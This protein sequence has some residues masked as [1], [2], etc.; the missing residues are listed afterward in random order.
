MQNI[1][2]LLIHYL[3]CTDY[4]PSMVLHN[5]A[6]STHYVLQRSLITGWGVHATMPSWTSRPGWRPRPAPPTTHRQPSRRKNRS[7]PC[8]FQLFWVRSTVDELRGRRPGSFS[9]TDYTPSMVFHN[10]MEPGAHRLGQQCSIHQIS[11]FRFLWNLHR[12]RTFRG[13]KPEVALYYSR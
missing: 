11:V 8:S 12:D 5:M 6:F 3:S 4:T 13:K 10:I 9:C 7:H 1:L 2:F